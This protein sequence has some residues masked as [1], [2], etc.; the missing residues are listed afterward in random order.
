MVAPLPFFRGPKQLLQVQVQVQVMVQAMT[1]GVIYLV[2]FV[3][4]G[5]LQSR[6]KWLK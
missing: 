4:R 3:L 5:R 2:K 1:A 6:T